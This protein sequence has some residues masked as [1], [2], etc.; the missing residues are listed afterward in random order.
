MDIKRAKEIASSPIMAYVTYNDMPI[1]IDNVNENHG[2]ARVYPLHQPT[3]TQEV[4]IT[5]LQER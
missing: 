4:Y 3:N 1:Y 2:T 5:N